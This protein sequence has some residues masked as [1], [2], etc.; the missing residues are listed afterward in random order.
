MAWNDLKDS[1]NPK[2]KKQSVDGYERTAELENK[3]NKAFA[4]A[5]KD[6]NGKL[7][8]EYLKSITTGAVSGPNIE[9]NRLFHLEGM[10]YLFAIMQDR[11]NKGKEK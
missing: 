1:K 2:V 4:I 11:I 10:R 6:D 8:L 3:I 9:A 7:V 5:F